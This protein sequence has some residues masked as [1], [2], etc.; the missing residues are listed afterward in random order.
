METELIISGVGFPPLS[1]RGCIQTLTPLEAG[2]FQRTI[3]GELIYTGKG[4]HQK[5]QSTITCQDK[6]SIA[7]EGLWRGSKVQVQCLQRLWQKGEGGEVILERPY[8]PGSIMIHGGEIIHIEGNRV[9]VS[10]G[11]G[12][13]VSYRPLLDMVVTN[14]SLLT[15]EWGMVCGWSLHLEEI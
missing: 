2:V 12:V 14:F 1:A 3:N 6:T 4:S 11:Q 8:V 9:Q 15:D 5:Y 7:I 10:V 13:F